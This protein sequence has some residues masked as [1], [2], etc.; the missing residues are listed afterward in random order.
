MSTNRRSFLTFGA[1]A[2]LLPF[3]GV[4]KVEASLQTSPMSLVATRDLLLPGLWTV[5]GNYGSDYE[6]D[7]MIDYK[8]DALIVKA[9]RFSTRAYLGF[10]ITRESIEKGYFKAEFKPSVDRLFKLVSQA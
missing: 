5:T 7:I 2:A 4:S 8:D 3:I 9:Y 10:A 6:S 1:L